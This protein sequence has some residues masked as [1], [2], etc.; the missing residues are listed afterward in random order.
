MKCPKCVEQG[1]KSR[2][3]HLH[4]TTTDAYYPPFYDEDGGYHVH[5]G[6]RVVSNFKCSLGHEFHTT[7]IGGPCPNSK[8]DWG[9]DLKPEVVMS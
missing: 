7:G 2:V 6:N 4:A 1:E 3:Q 5:D 9:R 8:C